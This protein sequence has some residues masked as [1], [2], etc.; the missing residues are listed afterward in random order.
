MGCLFGGHDDRFWYL[1]TVKAISKMVFWLIETILSFFSFVFIPQ[2]FQNRKRQNQ[3]SRHIQH[4]KSQTR[5][6]HSK[7][8]IFISKWVF[9][10]SNRH[11]DIEMSHFCSK[12]LILSRNRSFFSRK[13][14]FYSKIALTK[15]AIFIS[16]R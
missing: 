3:K 2:I 16:Y 11:F 4:F 10:I 13:S 12:S 6:D 8:V 5:D 1:N 9:F 15:W 7:W 14:R